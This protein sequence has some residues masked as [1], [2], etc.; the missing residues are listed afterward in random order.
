M[1]GWQWMP[2]RGL[3][4]SVLQRRFRSVL[5]RSVHQE[6]VAAKIK[7]ARELLTKTNLSLAAVAERSGF[8]H[9]EYLGTVLKKRLGKTPGEVRA[10]SRHGRLILRGRYSVSG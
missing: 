3:S 7:F 10:E 8:K 2:L 4:R 1:S 6:I 5:K 9:Q